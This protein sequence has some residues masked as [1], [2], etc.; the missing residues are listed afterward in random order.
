MVACPTASAATMTDRKV[1]ATARKT[2][3]AAFADPEAY[4]L[5]AIKLAAGANVLGFGTRVDKTFRA[6][7]TRV[8]LDQLYVGL[9]K[10]SASVT[11]SSGVPDA[12]VFMFATEPFAARRISGWSVSHRHI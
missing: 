2:H 4:A 8:S 11:L 7:L 12:H 5:E 1:D 6:R 9:G 3:V 10:A